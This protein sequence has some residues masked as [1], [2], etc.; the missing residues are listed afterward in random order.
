M[1]ESTAN[2]SPK[3]PETWNEYNAR[4]YQQDP[5]GISPEDKEV[6]G[7]TCGYWGFLMRWP[8]GSPVEGIIYFNFGAAMKA[9]RK[10]V[11]QLP[12]QNVA[13]HLRIK[14]MKEA[15]EELPEWFGKRP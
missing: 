7:A 10:Y 3:A 14:Q 11:F 2:N 13:N 6:W 12:E 1:S 9:A 5:H 15:G 8:D 4:R